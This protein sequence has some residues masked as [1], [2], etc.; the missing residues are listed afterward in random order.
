MDDTHVIW[1][2]R[3]FVRGT[4]GSALVSPLVTR[5]RGSEL[6]GEPWPISPPPLCVATADEKYGLGTS[7]LDEI[8]VHKVGWT[9]DA[10][11]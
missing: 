4:V 7:R 10:L 5:A 1:T 11:V 9:E 6:R 2:R 3:D 8:T